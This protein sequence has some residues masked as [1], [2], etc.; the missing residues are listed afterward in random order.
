[1]QSISFHGEVQMS[2]SGTRFVKCLAET[3]KSDRN[4]IVVGPPT[5]QHYILIIYTCN[6]TVLPFGRSILQFVLMGKRCLFASGAYFEKGRIL[7]H[8]LCEKGD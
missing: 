3:L 7:S 4:S 1:M 8:E 2:R 5:N 6:L